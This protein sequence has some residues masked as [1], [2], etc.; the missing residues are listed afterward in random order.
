[1]KNEIDPRLKLSPETALEDLI[2]LNLFSFDEKT[3]IARLA[4]KYKVEP[5][6]V[7]K[8]FQTLKD[9][10]A[11]KTDENGNLVCLLKKHTGKVVCRTPNQTLFVRFNGGDDIYVYNTKGAQV[12]STINFYV[13]QRFGKSEGII[14]SIDSEDFLYGTISKNADGIGFHFSADDHRIQDEIFVPSGE[15]YIDK[16]V[17]IKLDHSV[18]YIDNRSEKNVI[19]GDV[20]QDFGF[21]KFPLA[22]IDSIVDKYG[23]TKEPYNDAELRQL[24]S[25]PEDLT[26]EDKVGCVDR[27]DIPFITIDPEGCRDM[28]DAVHVEKTENGYRAY[29][30][31]ADVSYYITEGSPLDER[32]KMTAMSVYPGNG[33]IPMLPE[34]LSNG[35]CSLIKDKDRRVVMAVVDVDFDGSIRSYSF[36]NSIIN[37]KENLSYEAVDEIHNKLREADPIIKDSIDNSYLISDILVKVRND[38]GA[39]VFK[40]EEN[41]HIFNETGEKVI[42]A[43]DKTVV[44]STK[45]IESLM[46]LYDECEAKFK[47]ENNIISLYRI[48]E[49]PDKKDIE[50]IIQFAREVGIEVEDIKEDEI[51]EKE[52]KRSI[53][54]D[55]VHEILN[56]AKDTKYFDV[57]SNYAL[58]KQKKAKYSPDNVGHY[59]LGISKENAYEHAT[60]PI[61]RDPDKEGQRVIKSIINLLTD[62]KDKKHDFK[63]FKKLSNEEKQMIANSE[64]AKR[65]VDVNEWKQLGEYISQREIM[66]DKLEREIKRY[67]DA[68]W[69]EDQ[70]GGVF[71]GCVLKINP[72][73]TLIKLPR[74]NVTI[75]VPTL[76]LLKSDKIKV[77]DYKLSATLKSGKVERLAIGD[78]IYVKI[79]EVDINSRRV[80]GE[81]DF[82][83]EKR[84]TK[85]KASGIASCNNL[86]KLP[87]MFKY[88]ECIE[89]FINEMRNTK[90]EAPRNK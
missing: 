89:N 66:A 63:N 13:T 62:P 45:N 20:V 42:D 25:I 61:R 15:K 35:S 49:A 79:N 75:V 40:S 27:T 78:D 87:E 52:Q 56:K 54:G 36:E 4:G 6:K 14:E 58:V 72:A 24:D 64:Y 83:A 68:C 85:G 10:Y 74:E 88:E 19:I 11:I 71:K 38:R 46:I 17:K 48:H 70:I 2:N 51:E 7:E 59:G 65:N 82:E 30:A 34:K 53:Y 37:V 69:A 43:V 1:M 29:I 57:I 86:S 90:T 8:H 67:L 12:G 16:K 5:E 32:S 23:F 9:R 55:K 73:E 3:A 76:S 81:R 28:D 60:A 18:D 77:D 39:L 84:I 31:I 44:P 80:V 41:T 26:D 22:E 47:Q 21:A 33:V 50:N